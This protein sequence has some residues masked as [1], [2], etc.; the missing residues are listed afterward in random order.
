[1][2]SKGVQMDEYKGDANGTV[3]GSY[4]NDED[5][6]DQHDGTF[7]LARKYMGTAADQHDMSVLGRNQVLRVSIL[8]AFMPFALSTDH[9]SMQRNFRFISIVGF[10]S[11]LICTWEVILA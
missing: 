9:R 10:C 5:F 11:T 1:M 2:E 3:Q 7:N 6:V 8:L 4:V